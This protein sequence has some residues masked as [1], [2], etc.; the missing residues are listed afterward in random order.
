M[1]LQWPHH[2]AW[3]LTKTVLPATASSQLVPIGL[4]A[5]AM[6]SPWRLELDEDGLA[7]HGIIPALL[8]KLG[9]SC[10]SG[11]C[12]REQDES[13]HCNLRGPTVGWRPNKNS[14]PKLE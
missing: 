6:A 11:K 8:G 2:G 1:R 5:L 3:N 7:C 13:T 12:S 4:H 10:R 14:S 9:R